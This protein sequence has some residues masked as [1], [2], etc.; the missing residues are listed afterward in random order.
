MKKVILVT[1]DAEKEEVETK[2]AYEAKNFLWTLTYKSFEKLLNQASFL[3]V[4]RTFEPQKIAV[5]LRP[6]CSSGIILAYGLDDGL[7]ICG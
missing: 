4:K 1:R 7:Q 3:A 2:V 6:L 5:L